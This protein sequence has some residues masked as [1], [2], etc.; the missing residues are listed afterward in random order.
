MPFPQEAGGDQLFCLFALWGMIYE[1]LQVEIGH[2]NLLFLW[3]LQLNLSGQQLNISVCDK[4]IKEQF[5][6]W[7]TV[8]GGYYFRVAEWRGPSCRSWVR[9][10]REKTHLLPLLPLIFSQFHL[11]AIPNRKPGSKEPRGCSPYGS[12]SEG[13]ELDRQGERGELVV[14]KEYMQENCYLGAG[15]AR[16]DSKADWG[17]RD[18]KNNQM[19]WRSKGKGSGSDPWCPWL[20]KS[21]KT[22]AEPLGLATGDLHKKQL[23]WNVGNRGQ[24]M[25]WVF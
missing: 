17:A 8:T 9:N 4:E 22:W 1:E 3:D 21:G 18:Q 5:G 2:V 14:H 7:C 16:I 23:Q 13:P 25:K 15:S 11:S 10:Y 24:L 6:W 20:Q 19:T 12:A